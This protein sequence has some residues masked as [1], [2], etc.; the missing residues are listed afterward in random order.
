MS[1][2]LTKLN[3][4]RPVA[5]LPDGVMSL[6]LRLLLFAKES[7]AKFSCAPGGPNV[8]ERGG[9]PGKVIDLSASPGASVKK[10][11]ACGQDRPR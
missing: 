3:A 9:L 5:V 7:C 1:W 4:T 8:D 11:P 6:E 10:F 2:Q